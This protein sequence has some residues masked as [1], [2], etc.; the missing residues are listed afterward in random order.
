[1]VVFNRDIE[2][3]DNHDNYLNPKTKTWLRVTDNKGFIRGIE[4]LT[5]QKENFCDVCNLIT[6]LKDKINLVQVKSQIKQVKKA[7]NY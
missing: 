7:P 4:C 6:K 1:M 2:Y 3:N 5:S